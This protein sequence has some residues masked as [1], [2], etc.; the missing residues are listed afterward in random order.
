MGELLVGERIMVGAEH[1]YREVSDGTHARGSV[2]V[3]EYETAAVRA[4][5]PR[6]DRIPKR[7][8]LRLLRNCE[9]AQRHETTNTT[10]VEGHRWIVDGLDATQPAPPPIRLLAVGRSDTQPEDSD[11]SL[12]DEVARVDINSY[13]DA[14]NSVTVTGILGTNEGNVDTGSGEALHEGGVYAGGIN[15]EPTYFI[16]H[17]LFAQPIDKD[18]TIIAT[19]SVTLTYNAV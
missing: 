8:Q 15:N 10:C 12:N 13:N 16:N 11:R 2:V 14:G 19:I 7:Y 1:R 5:F 18:E 4:R 17:A 3:E 9:P 6:W